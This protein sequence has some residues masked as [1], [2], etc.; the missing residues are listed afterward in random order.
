M[1][2]GLRNPR[3][4][5]PSIQ[6]YKKKSKFK[7]ANPVDE[8]VQQ[9]RSRCCE[10]LQNLYSKIQLLNRQQIDVDILYVD[11]YVLEKLTSESYATIPSLIESLNLRDD[12]DRLGLSK[13]GKRSPGLDAAT[14]YSRLMVLGKP[15]SGK[16]TFLRHL[17]VAN[18]KREFLENYIPVFIELR[19][20]ANVSEFH[21]PN[22][23]HQEFGLADKRQTEEILQQGKVL[24]FLDRLDEIS[25]Q[26][27]RKIQDQIIS[28]SRYYYKNR[29]V[30]T[31]RTQT[32]EYILPGFEYVEVAD[33]NP[34][35]VEYFVQNWFFALAETQQQG[36]ELTEKLQS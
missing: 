33:F 36:I 34:R 14:Q 12:F 7:A 5:Y 26:L 21:L 6:K 15:G 31:C 17:A 8:L 25:T 28:F 27:R 19:F 2:C 32:S 1:K 9:V 23:I 11:V 10:K 24:I 35:Q 4:T 22:Y 16:S 30:I 13:R 20:I 29:F 3:R 18:C